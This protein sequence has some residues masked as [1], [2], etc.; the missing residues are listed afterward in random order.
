[1]ILLMNLI[2]KLRKIPKV[3]IDIQEYLSEGKNNIARF[4]IIMVSIKIS[5]QVDFGYLEEM[6][7][8]GMKIY[9]R[10]F[11]SNF[12]AGFQP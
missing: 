3:R 9:Y 4:K 5:L 10:P 7:G 8:G 1:M 12:S 11:N 6:F 2:T